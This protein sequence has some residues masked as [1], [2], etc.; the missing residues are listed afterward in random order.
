[1]HLNAQIQ[2]DNGTPILNFYNNWQ[3]YL[4]SYLYALLIE[5]TFLVQKPFYCMEMTECEHI[6]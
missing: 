4:E 3:F 2:I 6:Y 5:V 1:M